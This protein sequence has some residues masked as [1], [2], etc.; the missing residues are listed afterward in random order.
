MNKVIFLLTAS[1]FLLT[2]AACAQVTIKAE[3][4]KGKLTTDDLLTYKL[5]VT[6]ALK[7]MPNPQLP[8]FS[9]FHIISQAQSSS[10]SLGKSNYGIKLEYT[11][12]LKAFGPG[13]FTIGPSSIKIKGDT[14]LT[15]SFEVDVEQGKGRPQAQP[16]RKGPLPKQPPAPYSDQPKIT[17]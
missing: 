11:Y 12:L 3:I 8:D 4:D 10:I 6:S 14:Y 2:A 9:G 15:D 17:L 5:T 16:D 1:L 7:K 13:K